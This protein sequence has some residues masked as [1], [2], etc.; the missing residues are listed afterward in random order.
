MSEVDKNYTHED[1]NW[2]QRVHAEYVATR[3]FK[4]NWGF[5]TEGR[6]EM[7]NQKFD[8]RLVK[9]F[10]PAGG[11]WTVRAKKVPERT[12]APEDVVDSSQPLGERTALGAAERTHVGRMEKIKGM[13]TAFI[14]TS[15]RIGSRNTL[16]QFGVADYGLRNMTVE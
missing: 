3:H 7:K 16:E 2:R 5:L 14:N 4:E 9:Y 1:E 10:N 6:Q 11:T 15:S 13:N 8:T 12:G